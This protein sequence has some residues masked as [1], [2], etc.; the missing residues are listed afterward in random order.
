MSNGMSSSG[1]TR[2]ARTDD[3]DLGT[4]ERRV[5]RGRSGREEFI[6]EPLHELV[7]EDEGVENGILHDEPEPDSVQS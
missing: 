1:N 4:A 5:G 6:E 7:Q 3:G 2:Q